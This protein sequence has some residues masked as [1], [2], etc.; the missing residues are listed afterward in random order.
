MQEFLT[1]VHRHSGSPVARTAAN[2]VQVRGL[3]RAGE[4]CRRI[5]LRHLLRAAKHRLDAPA[6]L[7]LGM[8]EAELLWSHF[9]D[10]GRPVAQRST[11]T[12]ERNIGQFILF[13]WQLPVGMFKTKVQENAFFSAARSHSDGHGDAGNNLKSVFE[14]V[15]PANSRTE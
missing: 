13:F 11:R 3:T 15:S 5:D 4:A 9:A 10:V 6:R 2:D 12:K 7:S 14:V 1:N 8:G